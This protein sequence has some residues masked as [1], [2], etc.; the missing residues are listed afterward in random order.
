MFFFLTVQVRMQLDC[1]IVP[2]RQHQA[3]I[4]KIVKT[5]QAP[6]LL[7]QCP[8]TSQSESCSQPQQND[9][10]TTGDRPVQS[11][12]DFI[13]TQD[14]LN[15][16]A[17]RY[18]DVVPPTHEALSE[19]LVYMERVRNVL[20]VDKGTGSL[21]LTLECSSLQ[22]LDGL[23]EDYRSGHLNE[24]VQK[25]LVTEELL[26]EFGLVGVKMTTTILE[27]EYLACRKYFLYIQGELLCFLNYVTGR[28]VI[29]SC[30]PYRKRFA[31]DCR[32]PGPF[33]YK[34]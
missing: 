20:V 1:E 28:R 7:S 34:K 23:W 13:T 24:V 26:Q 11:Q 10:L 9:G 17:V 25:L 18:L 14:V 6:Q 33:I 3:E 31:L 30:I 32:I 8:T 21:I 27:E 15:R 16:I 2:A 5:S 29:F 4:V 19:F 12:R 22:I